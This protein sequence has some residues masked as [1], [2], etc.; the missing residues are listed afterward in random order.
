MQTQGRA[1]TRLRYRFSNLEQARAHVQAPEGHWLFFYRD[2]KLRLL[3]WA[4][5][6]VEFRFDD[7]APARLLHGF[8]IDSLEGSGTWIELLDPRAILSAARYTRESPRWGCNLDVEI[9]AEGRVEAG[10]LLDLSTGGARLSGISRFSPGRAVEL[11]LLS[12]DRLTFRDLSFGRVAW[13]QGSERG[14][15]F[16]SNDAIGRSAVSRLVTEV[17]SQWRR[18]WESV[19]PH[20]CCRDEGVVTPE[21][22]RLPRADDVTGKIAL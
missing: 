12:D 3:P 15:Q 11:R 6:C 5:V 20:F 14:V 9:R 8:A 10:R 19:H 2:D 4:P 17:E 21:A 13:S 7:G 16:D 1:T 18:T 22:P